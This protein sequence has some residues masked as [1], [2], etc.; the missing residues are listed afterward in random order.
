V[1]IAEVNWLNQAVREHAQ[2]GRKH[3]NACERSSFATFGV[4]GSAFRLTTG[5]YAKEQTN[6]KT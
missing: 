5:R 1:Y 6:D 4:G 2:G 3:A